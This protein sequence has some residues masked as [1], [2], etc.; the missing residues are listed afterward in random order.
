MNQRPLHIKVDE[1][2]PPLLAQRLREQGYVATTVVEEGMGGW[3]DNALWQAIQAEGK[4]LITADKGFA[5]VQTHPPGTHA[6]LLL[7]RPDSDGIFPLLF[8]LDE[9]LA[10]QRLE[11]LQGTIAVATPRG[12]RIRR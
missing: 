3:K 10:S 11:M 9:V 4:F 1:D 6:G 8:L 12:V 5:N 7:L 2:L